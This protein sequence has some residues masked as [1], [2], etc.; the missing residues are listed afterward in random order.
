MAERAG[1]EVI[2]ESSRATSRDLA[3]GSSSGLFVISGIGILN[4][5]WIFRQRRIRLWR[6]KLDI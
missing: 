1:E 5:F 2:E 3:V 4:L 6:K